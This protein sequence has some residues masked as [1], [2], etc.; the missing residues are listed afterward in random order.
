MM[1]TAQCQDARV[2]AQIERLQFISGDPLVSLW[3]AN[4]NVQAGV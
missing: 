1:P 4:R 3:G 2:G